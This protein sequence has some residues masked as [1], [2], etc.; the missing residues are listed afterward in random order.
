MAFLIRQLAVQFVVGL[1]LIIFLATPRDVEGIGDRLQIALPLAGWA[2]AYATGQGVTYFGRY[3]ILEVGIKGPKFLLGDLPINQRPNGGDMGF[4][5]GHTAAATFGATA[6]AQSCVRHSPTATAA[7]ILGAGFTGAS[8]MDADKHTIWQVLAGAVWG[9]LAQALVLARFDAWFRRVAMRLGGLIQRMRGL[10]AELTKIGFGVLLLAFL[11]QPAQAEFELGAYIGPQIAHDSN[12]DGNDPT[13]VGNF[14]IKAAW[15]GRSFENPLHY[16]V[17][18]TLWRNERFGWHFDFDHQ[19][20]YADDNTLATSG[21]TELEFTDGLN[22]V[23]VGPIW[24]WNFAQAPRLR[25][26]AGVGAG[27]SLPYVE[28]QSTPTSTPTEGLEIGGPAVAW[29]AGL[30]YAIN[31]RWAVFGE[32]KGTYHWIDVD[33]EGGGNL[34]T[35]IGTHAINIGVTYT[36]N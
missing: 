16:G 9:W 2:C 15:D 25:S 27:L 32:Y 7:V 36:W 10:P 30:R 6:L 18:A 26:Y 19:K 20:V 21:F 4:P 23:T 1:V 8:R 33:L 28:V 13:G 14:S 17:R 24:R 5:S 29:M 34:D 12:V 11:A 3:L 22:A 31:D 35:E